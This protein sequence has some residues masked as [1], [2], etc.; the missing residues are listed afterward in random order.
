MYRPLIYFKLT[1]FLQIVLNL[2]NLPIDIIIQINKFI[3]QLAKNWCYHQESFVRITQLLRN[4]L[5]IITKNNTNE[6]CTT[7]L[8]MMIWSLQKIIN[9]KKCGPVMICAFIDLLGHFA[10]KNNGSF[11]AT[12]NVNINMVKPIN[13]K[14]ILCYINSP[15]LQVR[16][17]VIKYIKV[18]CNNYEE[19]PNTYSI[20]YDD[21]FNIILKN[22]HEGFIVDSDISEEEYDD[23]YTNRISTYLLYMQT[24]LISST[25][26]RQKSLF[27]IFQTV[28]DKKIDLNLVISL[29]KGVAIE[30][31]I[32]SYMVLLE[33]NLNFLL[34]NWHLKYTTFKDFPINLF[35]CQTV[36]QF[37]KEYD[38]E[39]IPILVIKNDLD[40]LNSK[41]TICKIVEEHFSVIYSYM[42]AI[43][44]GNV[45]FLNHNDIK[46]CIEN[47]LSQA[48]FNELTRSQFPNILLKCIQMVVINTEQPINPIQ[49]NSDQFLNI[50]NIFQNT[51]VKS[52][53]PFLLIMSN[54]QS[55]CIQK[56]VHFL[57]V[58]IFKKSTPEL[59]IQ[60]LFQYSFFM[61]LLFNQLLKCSDIDE[62]TYFLLYQSV[63][64]TITLID[65]NYFEIQ[66]DVLE[67]LEWLFINTQNILK[68]NINQIQNLVTSTFKLLVKNN[69]SLNEKL[70]NL[71]SCLKKMSDQDTNKKLK[72]N[73]TLEEDIIDFLS[74]ENESTDT[75][76]SLQHIKLKLKI[77]EQL[78]QNMYEE[79]QRMRG[80]SEDCVNSILHRFICKLIHLS[81][82][83][84]SE[85]QILAASCLGIL[86]P[87]DLTTLILQP[88]PKILKLESNISPE[89]SFIKHIVVMLLNY[90]SDSNISVMEASNITLFKIIATREGQSLY[91]RLGKRMLYPFKELH[92]EDQ[93]VELSFNIEQFNLI[94]DVDQIWCPIDLSISYNKWLTSL[95]KQLLETLQGFCKSVLPI[96]ENKPMFCENILP[97]LIYFLLGKPSTRTIINKH[98]NCFFIKHNEIEKEKRSKKI[99]SNV[100]HASDLC[101]N[102]YFNKS[103]L[104]CLLNI[105]NFIRHQ[106]KNPLQ[107]LLDINYLYVSRAAQFCSA[108]FTSILYLE[109]WCD[110]EFKKMEKD[111]CSMT[112][113][114]VDTITEMLRDDGLLLQSI[115]NESY[116]SIGDPDAVEGCGSSYLLSLSSRTQYYQLI[117]KW[118]RVMENCDLQQ[119]SNIVPQ[120]Y[121]DALSNSGLQNIAHIM[122]SNNDSSKYDYCW[123]LDKWDLPDNGD[124]SFEAL[125]YHSLRYVHQKNTDSAISMIREAR[126]VVVNYISCASLESTATIY[127]PLAK[128]KMIEDLE[129]FISMPDR[130]TLFEN[131]LNCKTLR[132]NEFIHINKI[133]SQRAKL[134]EIHGDSRSGIIKLNIAEVARK[135]DWLQEAGRNLASVV[136]LKNDQKH[137]ILW[138]KVEEARLLWQRNDSHMA[139]VLLKSVVEELYNYEY[140]LLHSLALQLYGSWIE[141]TKSEPASDIIR[142]YFQKSIGNLQQESIDKKE[143]GLECKKVLSEAYKH[144]S[145]FTDTLYQQLSKYLKTEAIQKR[146]N[147]VENDKKKGKDLL[148]S[149]RSTKDSEKLKAG[150]YLMNQCNIDKSDI[151]N[152]N[153]EKTSYLKI[154]LQN[155]LQ[156]MKLDDESELPIYR[157]I[158]LWLEN[159]ENNE[160]NTMVDKELKNNSSY[161][162]ITVLPQLVPHL[163]VSYEHNF[164]KSLENLINRC[165]IEHPYQTIPIVYAIANSNIDHVYIQCKPST[166]N[167]ETR[168]LA[169]KRLMSNWKTHTKI[170]SVVMNT[171]KLYEAFIHLA[172]KKFPR[173]TNQ[174]LEIPNNQPLMK[175]KLS[176]NFMYPTAAL[177][178]NKYGHY[179]NIICIDRFKSSFL[180]PGGIHEPKKVDCICSDGFIRSL[181]LKGNEDM[182]QDAVMQQVFGLMNRLLLS[183]KS[184]TKK[185]LTIRTYKVIPFS[186]Q[187]G[188]AEWCVNTISLGDY[189]IG[190]NSTSGAHQKYRPYDMLPVDARNVIKKSRDNRDSQYTKLKKYLAVCEKLKPVFRYYFFEKFVSPSIWFERRQ[191]YIYSVATTSMIGY[192]LG[193]GDRHC[194][195]ILIDNNTAELIHIDFGVAFEQGFLL[196]TPETVPFRLSRDIV[197]GMGICGIEGTFR[198][199]CEKTMSVLRQNQDVIVTV[200]EVLLYD[201]C[202]QWT[203]TEEKAALLQ[204]QST[205]QNANINLIEVNKLAERS[206]NKIRVKLCG[207]EEAGSAASVNGQVNRLIQ[208]ARDPAN[209]SLLFHGWQAYL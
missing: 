124:Q 97:H 207:M 68:L 11:G 12:W 102:I 121:L 192:I 70:S 178:L 61:K 81:K 45:P 96:A 73:N 139:K 147:E 177:P 23:E 31:K 125:H 164:H 29:L 196:N 95:T 203:L 115:L 105:V 114:P 84:D 188:I 144:L 51:L 108:H 87:A 15:F 46:N 162:F 179:Q 69:P 43:E 42:L 33:N 186:Q 176:D 209:L 82:S 85:V 60:S 181:L 157:I 75:N 184:T 110:K 143:F 14:N 158:S 202:Y 93:D 153:V 161:K 112:F 35:S 150:V 63:R 204:N 106:Q 27:E 17:A 99:S 141:E 189:L 52:K 64:S 38:F 132:S 152:I 126:L 72:E 190:K 160:I 57:Y 123:Q 37:Y 65:Q 71:L 58:N 131:W 175:I 91:E 174:R 53:N 149:A 146:I 113:N 170:G 55:N 19:N 198:K 16:I 127:S 5:K 173:S 62:F 135:N 28:N 44:I 20:N 195:N 6:V 185:K 67:Y 94:I 101:E 80:F 83:S 22:L 54:K 109:L 145:Q 197:D 32:K 48:H 88:E 138:S 104:Q 167:E 180:I 34:W 74:E 206:L 156:L 21:M 76:Q 111:H 50:M 205:I 25:K 199:Y 8:L 136:S 169:A 187:S 194:Q 41:T 10:Y 120:D 86:G 30:L 66:H 56:I 154:A 165:A 151:N 166:N 13:P 47:I 79:L 118:D 1:N 107:E 140:P 137:T 171:E 78:L 142:K 129:D 191:S 200:I 134:L 119:T 18:M 128:L 117:R 26:Y 103:A 89:Y 208:Q 7:N 100:C 2:D 90:L 183:N 159:K 39:I 24:L 201:P 168:V 3:K 77:N 130:N 59:R 182:R 193:L 163:S 4:A 148:E 133:L 98:I 116:K 36:E 92:I 49:I 172:Y 122:A 40:L 9:S 155:Y